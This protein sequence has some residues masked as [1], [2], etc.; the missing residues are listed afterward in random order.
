LDSG[1]RVHAGLD[2]VGVVA[3][4]VGVGLVLEAETLV[5][6]GAG[7]LLLVGAGPVRVARLAGFTLPSVITQAIVLIVKKKLG[8][9]H[10]RR[11]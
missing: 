3:K 11:H 2:E 6:L 7:V 1:F 8:C 9:V 4:V 5:G 10:K